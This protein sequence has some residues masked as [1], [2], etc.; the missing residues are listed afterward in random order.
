MHKSSSKF[1]TKDLLIQTAIKMFQENGTES[2]SIQEICKRAEVTRSAFYYHFENKDVLY[3]RIGD[4]VSMASREKIDPGYGRPYYHQLWAF[5]EP[6]LEMQIDVGA[7]IMNHVCLAHTVKKTEPDYYSYVDD[8]MKK[9]M[10]TLITCA[11]SER[12]ILSTATP[13]DLLLTSY[14]AIRGVNIRWLF[15][16][17]MLD[18]LRESKRVMDTVFLPADGFK[19]L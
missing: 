1:N 6:Y 7:D 11:Q 13:E 2:T 16:Q 4:W 14:A 17:G 15:Q 18:M 19:L 8:K 12:Q 3:E 9:S 5:F 10:L